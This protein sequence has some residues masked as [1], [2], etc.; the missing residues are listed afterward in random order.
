MHTGAKHTDEITVLR[1]KTAAFFLEN[2]HCAATAGFGAVMAL[3]VAQELRLYARHGPGHPGRQGRLSGI[4]SFLLKPI[5]F[6]AF[7][8]ARGALNG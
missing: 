4:S 6:G 3:L 1:L 2:E 8:W 7:V 5:F